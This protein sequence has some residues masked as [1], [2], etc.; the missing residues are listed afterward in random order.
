MAAYWDEKK[1][2]TNLAKHGI[3][4]SLFGLFDWDRVVFLPPDF[5]EGERRERAVSLIAGRLALAVFTDRDD[6]IRLI[7]LRPATKPE[8]RI[9][10]HG[11]GKAGGNR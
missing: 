11:Q 2:Q 3:D 8:Q 9:W 10:T 5:A 6:E 7:S 1:R 4:F